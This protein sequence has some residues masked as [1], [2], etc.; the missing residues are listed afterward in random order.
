M[1]ML[2]M[3]DAVFVD[4]LVDFDKYW[5][6]DEQAWPLIIILVSGPLIM[7]RARLGYIV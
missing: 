3:R 6:W 7:T 4:I 2:P 1:E 5:I